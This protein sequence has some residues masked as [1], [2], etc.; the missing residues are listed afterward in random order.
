[1]EA[2]I[3]TGSGSTHTEK[4]CICHTSEKLSPCH[5]CSLVFHSECMPAGWVRNSLNQLFCSIC[6]DRKWDRSPPVLTP[7][8]SPRA[9]QAR[10]HES[11]VAAG[12]TG[13]DNPTTSASRPD[14]GTVS[15]ID[16][17]SAHNLQN[18]GSAGQIPVIVPGGVASNSNQAVDTSTLE[19]K[20]RQRKSRYSTLAAD[21]DLALATIYREVESIPLLRSQFEDLRAENAQQSQTIKIYEQNLIALRREIERLKTHASNSESVNKELNELRERNS[22]LE[23]EL[24][25]SMQQ[26]AAAK[27]LKER[28]AQLLNN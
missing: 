11:V 19:P 14:H 26:S 25:L 2:D 10:L 21:V 16:Q 22:S 28:L 5:T 6:V 9:Q 15:S 18:S 7:P 24:Q 4:C 20:R 13:D 1:M 17:S 23:A 12:G 3:S 8:V 27:E